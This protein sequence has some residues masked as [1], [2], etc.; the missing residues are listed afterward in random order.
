MGKTINKCL[1]S[2]LCSPTKK[3]AVVSG[4]TNKIGLYVQQ[5]WMILF[6]KNQKLTTQLKN[7]FYR[8]DIVH[9]MPGMKD[10]KIIWDNNGIKSRVCK[11]F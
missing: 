1:K 10:E 4:V 5:K 2:L 8:N 6:Q 11:F 7:F 3:R 9:T